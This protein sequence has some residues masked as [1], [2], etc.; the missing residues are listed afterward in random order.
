[1]LGLFFFTWN[2]SWAVTLRSAP[3]SGAL[4]THSVIH[5]HIPPTLGLLSTCE[6]YIYYDHQDLSPFSSSLTSHFAVRSPATP[7]SACF[8]T[9]LAMYL[10]CLRNI[11]QC[12]CLPAVPY[13]LHNLICL[14]VH[15][16]LRCYDDRAQ[17][18][19]PVTVA[20]TNH[21]C[22]VITTRYADRVALCQNTDIRTR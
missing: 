15:V 16:H 11:Y 19:R 18:L 7:T 10:L 20:L 9:L 21:S 13:L 1:M 2:P 17:P 22:N 5:T 12:I 6:D 14:C 8:L 4:G 3:T